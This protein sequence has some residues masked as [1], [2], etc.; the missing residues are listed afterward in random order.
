MKEYICPVCGSIKMSEDD[1][2]PCVFCGCNKRIEIP[3]TES[4][5]VKDY[6]S[7]LDNREIAGYV[8]RD[9]SDSLTPAERAY[10]EYFCRKY[11]FTSDQFNPDTYQTRAEFEIAKKPFNY[12]PHESTQAAFR[13]YDYL[14]T[15]LPPVGEAAIAQEK[16][17]EEKEKAQVKAQAADGCSAFLIVVFGGIGIIA[18]A[19]F[20][21]WAM[22]AMACGDGTLAANALPAVLA[23]IA[24][25]YFGHK[26]FTKW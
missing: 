14:P 4:A 26:F 25:I 12:Y 13:K 3:S 24:V 15:Y 19:I 11:V 2:S 5:D 22:M 23:L 21:L 7:N 6:F 10:K 9:T 16:Q 8:M 17:L 20:A 1:K 18:V